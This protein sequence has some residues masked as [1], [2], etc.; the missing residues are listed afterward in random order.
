LELPTLSERQHFRAFTA[1]LVEGERAR[2]ILAVLDEH[3]L[4]P[5]GLRSLAPSD[6][7]YCARYAG[8]PWERDSA[9]HQ[10]TVWRLHRPSV[11]RGRAVAGR[12]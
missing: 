7:A 3:L 2:R 12:S 11:E 9:Y 1:P 4:T 8:S 6:P 5:R 10:G